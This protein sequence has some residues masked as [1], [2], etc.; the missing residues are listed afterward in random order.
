MR[1]R[2]VPIW[3][4]AAVAAL[5]GQI[6]TAEALPGLAATVI[7][8]QIALMLIGTVAFSALAFHS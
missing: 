5:P 8:A 4:V 7:F 2:L 6:L 1:W 3:I